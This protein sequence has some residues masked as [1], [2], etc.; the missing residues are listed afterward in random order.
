MAFFRSI[1]E[2]ISNISKN[3]YP[4]PHIE[5]ADL[6]IVDSSALCCPVCF[7]VYSHAP[8]ILSCGH[9]FCSLCIKGITSRDHLTERVNND[10]TFSCPMCRERCSSKRIV[11]NYVVEDILSK[12]G[13]LP[14]DEKAKEVVQIATLKLSKQRL[15]SKC[16]EQASVIAR[17]K[18]ANEEVKRREFR[19]YSL[20]LISF[21]LYIVLSKY[22]GYFR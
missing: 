22:F 1:L 6:I 10:L 16:Q 21:A 8:L 15:E 12:V 9:T 18:R 14:K 13:D 20:F 17:Y 4:V 5:G 3:K 11:K 19:N 7:N 2:K